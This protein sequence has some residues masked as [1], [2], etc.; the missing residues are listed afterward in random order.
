V[1]VGPLKECRLERKIVELGFASSDLH[2]VDNHEPVDIR[3]PFYELT[4]IA[5]LPNIPC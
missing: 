4:L 5:K 2:F 3:L 1:S